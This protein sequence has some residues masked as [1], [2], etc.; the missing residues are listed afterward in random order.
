MTKNVPLLLFSALALLGGGL[1]A[2]SFATSSLPEHL[3]EEGVAVDANEL[4][5]MRRELQTLK[6]ELH[7]VRKEQSS[8]KELRIPERPGDPTP[9]KKRKVD[10]PDV[11]PSMIQD[12]EAELRYRVQL[13]GVVDEEAVDPKWASTAESELEGRFHSL[14][15]KGIALEVLSLKCASTV[16]RVEITNGGEG[17]PVSGLRSLTQTI[18]WDGDGYAHIDPDDPSRVLMYVSRDGMAL[19]RPA[20]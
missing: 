19:P 8:S 14:R 10:S 12:K 16:C 2:A 9:T 3:G 13:A 20:G 11:A 18:P 6:R 5:K 7:H 4:Q 17:P 1:L 15:T